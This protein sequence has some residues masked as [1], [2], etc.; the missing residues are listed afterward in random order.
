MEKKTHESVGIKITKMKCN[1]VLPFLFI[2]TIFTFQIS[3]ITT[4]TVLVNVYHFP[5]VFILTRCYS[6]VNAVLH[7][8]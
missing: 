5:S 7:L 4:S 3:L 8:A 2:Y 6:I 1:T